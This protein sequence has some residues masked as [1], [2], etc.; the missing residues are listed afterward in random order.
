MEPG[1]HR[2]ARR[3][4]EDREIPVTMLLEDVLPIVMLDTLGS[5]VTRVSSVLLILSISVSHGEDLIQSISNKLYLRGINALSKISAQTSFHPLKHFYC[6][7]KKTAYML[8]NERVSWNCV[9]YYLKPSKTRYPSKSQVENWL[10]QC[11][12]LTNWKMK[13]K[14]NNIIFIYTPIKQN[15]REL[16]Q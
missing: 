10:Q 12:G 2:P 6:K 3:P 8:T 4:V 16:I 7:K 5:F 9:S 14:T 1:V 11:H 13:R 15:R